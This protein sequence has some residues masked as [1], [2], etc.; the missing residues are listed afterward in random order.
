MKKQIALSLSL[1]AVLGVSACDHYSNE[2]ASLEQSVA[3]ITPASG[4][5]KF[6]NQ[7]PF[8]QHLLQG[9]IAQAGFEQSVGDYKAAKYYTTCASLIN[10]GKLVEP[11]SLKRK[12]MRGVS[13]D[14]VALLSNARAELM[15]A[16]DIKAIPENRQNLAAAQVAFDCWVDQESE[17]KQGSPCQ[18]AF[19][20]AMANVIEKP[21][22]EPQLEIA[23]FGY[24]QLT[25]EQYIPAQIEPAAG[26]ETFQAPQPLQQ[27][28]SIKTQSRVSV[29]DSASAYR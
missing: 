13:S 7:M 21:V 8:S 6:D 23:P 4:G 22:Y 10:K 11:M 9:Y 29:Y 15:S 12:K 3:S 27:G 16:L 17:N 2:M 14:R 5:A 18:A 19:K 26:I 25:Q 24:E 20:Q 28:V 1:I